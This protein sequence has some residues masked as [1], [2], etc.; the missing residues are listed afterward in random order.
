MLETSKNQLVPLLQEVDSL[1]R[2]VRNS[3]SSPWRKIRGLGILPSLQ[4]AAKGDEPLVQLV[5]HL[6]R[7]LF[8]GL[9]I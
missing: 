6:S 3:K 7:D 4:A 1:S 2:K 5:L 9:E 8:L